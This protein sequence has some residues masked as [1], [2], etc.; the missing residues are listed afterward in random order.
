MKNKLK[1]VSE[2]FKGLTTNEYLVLLFVVAS[3]LSVYFISALIL[4]LP[5]YIFA[6]R[7]WK[8]ALP[9]NAFDWFLLIFAALAFLSTLIFAKDGVV[10]HFT[11][12]REYLCFLAVGILILC[13]D[14]FFFL[15]VMTKHTFQLSLR[16]A[17]AMSILTFTV[18][19]IQKILGIYPD[20]INHPGRV[21]SLYINENYYGMA[22][23]FVLL[24]TLYLLLKTKKKSFN[25]FYSFVFIINVI[26]LWFCQ[27]RM[28][29]IVVAFSVL[30][31]LI[32]SKP[33]AALYYIAIFA[34]GSF[35]IIMHPSILPRFD[36]T[37]SYLNFRIGIW[38]CALESFKRFP[39][40]GRGYFAYSAI[41]R[42]HYLNVYYPAL[43]AHNIYMEVLINFGIIG[44]VFLL[45]Y[46]Y[47]KVKQCIQNCIKARDKASLA[48][49]LA[50]VCGIL[51]HGLADNTI[52]WPQTGFFAV[53]L[54]AKPEVYVNDQ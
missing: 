30:I 18:A 3:F 24:I 4:L 53:L 25:V 27:T 51:I 50:I 15:D 1:L 47:D 52:F 19:L 54:L 33:K 11:L 37:T 42:E 39:L 45:L 28:A 12:K 44:S 48:F 10:D 26:A 40:L 32:L 9:K 34:L 20:P 49:V 17:T 43:H 46:C 31:F 22:L 29:Y 13:F 8:K 23:E 5:I 35:L 7:Q 21:A 38:Q 6:T 16:I 14:I 2:A 36:S 41:W